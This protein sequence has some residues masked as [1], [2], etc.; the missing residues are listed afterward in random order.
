M[1]ELSFL[2]QDRKKRKIYFLQGDGELDINET[3]DHRAP[4]PAQR[5]WKILVAA[6]SWKALKKEQYEVQGLSFAEELPKDKTAN[7]VY[8]EGRADP[9]TQRRC[10]TMPMP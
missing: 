7:L 9:T 2:A 3:Q 6:S 4:R 10:P 8:V 1:K 5:R